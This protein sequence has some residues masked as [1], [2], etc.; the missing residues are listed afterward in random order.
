[1]S[2]A[3]MVIAYS[4][5]MTILI[6]KSDEAQNLIVRD[7]PK[8]DYFTIT[9]RVWSSNRLLFDEKSVVINRPKRVLAR[10]LAR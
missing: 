3:L 4:Q 5:K 9:Q 2:R 7:Q 10:V 6:V 1:M 8:K